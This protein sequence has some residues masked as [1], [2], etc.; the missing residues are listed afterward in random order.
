[1]INVLKNEKFQLET[2]KTEWNYEFAKGI[3]EYEVVE[4]FKIYIE[5]LTKRIIDDLGLEPKKR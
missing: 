1:M 3:N 2:L 5:I 4:R